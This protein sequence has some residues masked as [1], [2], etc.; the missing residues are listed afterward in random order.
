LK[1]TI[2]IPQSKTKR[3]NTEPRLVTVFVND[4]FDGLSEKKYWV[5]PK[6]SKFDF[7]LP[8][9]IEYVYRS[10]SIDCNFF[11]KVTY[12]NKDKTREE[13]IELVPS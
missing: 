10:N 1:H 13:T 5:S 3:Y 12:Y 4:G 11:V 9:H 2:F 8:D 6:Q 7:D